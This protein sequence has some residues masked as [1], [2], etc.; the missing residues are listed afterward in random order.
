VSISAKSYESTLSRARNAE[1]P[2]NSSEANLFCIALLTLSTAM[3]YKSGMARPS[4]ATISDSAT[5]P[6]N[7]LSDM[8]RPRRWFEVCRVLLVAFGGHISALYLLLHRPSARPKRRIS[9]RSEVF[10]RKSRPCYCSDTSCHV[11]A[12]DSGVSVIARCSLANGHHTES[13]SDCAPKALCNTKARRS[14]ENVRR[15]RR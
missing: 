15:G 3:L 9:N 6:L 14:R 12:S 5:A 2:S 1:W 7:E 11:A 4:D 13:L 10:C 8:E